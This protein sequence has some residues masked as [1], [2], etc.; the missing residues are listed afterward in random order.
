VSDIRF[1]CQDVRDGVPT[2]VDGCVSGGGGGFD[3]VLCRYSAFLY[4]T[5]EEAQ[6]A[7]N[8]MAEVLERMYSL[9]M[10]MHCCMYMCMRVC[11]YVCVCVYKCM[12]SRGHEDVYAE[13]MHTHLVAVYVCLCVCMYVYIVEVKAGER[14]YACRTP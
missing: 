11:S 13:Y 5:A 12:Y 1:E 8:A 3:L 10:Y 6:T 7:L 14:T 9:S 4:L 2:G